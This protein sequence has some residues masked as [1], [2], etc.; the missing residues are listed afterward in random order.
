MGLRQSSR[1]ERTAPRN[2]SASATVDLSLFC[3]RPAALSPRH[4][5]ESLRV[6]STNSF[7]GPIVIQN[8]PL[9]HYVCGEP[10]THSNSFFEALHGI[11]HELSK[12][13]VFQINVRG[14][15]V[16]PPLRLELESKMIRTSTSLSSVASPRATEP[17][18][19]IEWIWSFSSA[20]SC[21]VSLSTGC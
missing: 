3:S 5:C 18:S 4:S 9:T 12:D 17:N 13:F 8:N 16:D 19:T 1:T 11:E 21:R 14:D 10:G 20:R 2:V 15:L 6:L 7:V